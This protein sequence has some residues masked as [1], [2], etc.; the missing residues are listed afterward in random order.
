MIERSMLGSRLRRKVS[1]K[2]IVALLLYMGAF[3]LEVKLKI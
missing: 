1:T 3:G 2:T